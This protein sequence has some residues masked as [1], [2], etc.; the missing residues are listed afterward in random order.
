MAQIKIYAL[1][2]TLR[3]RQSAISDAVHT[4][5]VEVLALPP[6]KRFHRF[7]G[8]DA[9]DFF[10]PADRSENYLILEISMFEGRTPQTKKALI[11]ALF[12]NLKASGIASQD[13]E[14]TIFETPR[15][16]WGIRGQAGDD[17]SLSYQVEI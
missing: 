4:A 3:G 6:N 7:F 11:Y 10:F 15:A 1:S 12:A 17:L 14:I 13:V 2:S 8:L 16:N 5:V 9:S